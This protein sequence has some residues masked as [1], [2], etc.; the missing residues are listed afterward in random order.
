MLAS[1]SSFTGQNWRVVIHDDGT[2]PDDARAWFRVRF[3]QGGIIERVEADSTM[4][5][6]LNGFPKCLEYRARHPL[7][8]KIFD[9]PH[10]AEGSRFMVFDSD[11]LF[12]SRPDEI[13]RW[14]S[15]GEGGCWFNA[16]VKDGTLITKQEA[17]EKLGVS[18]WARV[19]S[20]LCLLPREAL[21]L[22]LCEA[23]LR[24]TA[25]TSGHV[26]RIEQTLFAVCASKYG[27]G[28][29]LPATYEVSLS[30]NAAPD[31]VARHYVGAVRNRFYAEGLARLSPILLGRSAARPSV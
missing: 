20:G 15:D 10:F 4:S 14:V 31:A 6:A 9:M 3:P 29:L 11:I 5:G 17:E 23:C 12:F 13:L 18:L 16:D 1:W 7:S 27:R 22:E 19:N 2:L 25:V 8:L 21:S 28:G 24:E 30:R 26:W